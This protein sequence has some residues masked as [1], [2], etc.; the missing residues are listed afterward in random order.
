[1][2]EE[3]GQVGTAAKQVEGT[4]LELALSRKFIEPHRGKIWRIEPCTN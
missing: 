4:G 1:V 2:F 3:F